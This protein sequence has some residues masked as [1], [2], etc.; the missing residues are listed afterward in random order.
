LKAQEI[1]TFQA[2]VLQQG[3]AGWPQQ[4]AL[5]GFALDANPLKTSKVHETC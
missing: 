1:L 4:G 2:Y 3:L 5:T